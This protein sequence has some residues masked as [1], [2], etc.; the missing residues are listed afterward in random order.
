MQGGLNPK[1]K[2]KG[3]SLDYYLEIVKNLKQAFPDLHLHAFSPQE[4]QFIAREDGLSY[5]KV[6]ASL[7]EA[8]VNSL[9]GR[10]AEVLVDEVRRVICPEKIDACHLVRNSR[11]CSSLGVTYHQYHA[12]RSY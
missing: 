1:A 2:I 4:V 3:N 9:R 10:P 11:Y 7:Q 8:G 5:E 12:L 6:I